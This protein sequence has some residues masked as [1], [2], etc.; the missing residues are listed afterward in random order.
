MERYTVNVSREGQTI[1]VTMEEGVADGFVGR[2]SDVAA[3]LEDLA[4]QLRDAPNTHFEQK[5]SGPGKRLRA[6]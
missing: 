4:R 2:G 1:T 3:A 6:V 5:E